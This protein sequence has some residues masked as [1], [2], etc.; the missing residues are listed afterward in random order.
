MIFAELAALPDTAGG[1]VFPTLHAERPML[2]GRPVL[3]HPRPADAGGECALGG[4][5]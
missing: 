2:Y 1:L 5:R 3:I 4:F